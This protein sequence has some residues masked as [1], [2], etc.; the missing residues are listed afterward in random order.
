MA[1]AVTGE[2]LE[3]KSYFKIRL[4]SLLRSPCISS[5]DFSDFDYSHCIV[6]VR[7]KYKTRFESENT[8]VT[9]PLSDNQKE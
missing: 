3:W 2:K 9:T 6:K 8:G 4:L 1:S 7:H 5:S